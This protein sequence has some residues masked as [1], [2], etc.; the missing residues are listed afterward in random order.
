MKINAV[1]TKPKLL[2]NKAHFESSIVY[3]VS[4][5]LLAFIFGTVICV[6]DNNF[7]SANLFETFTNFITNFSNNSF[8]EVLLSNLFTEII[9]MTTIFLLGTSFIGKIPVY[10]VTFIKMSGIS[11]FVTYLFSSYGISG[12]EY[13]I[14]IMLPST[15]VQIFYVLILN[16]RCSLLSSKIK[17]KLFDDAENNLDIK[18][19]AI[20]TAFVFVLIVISSVL[21]SVCIKLFSSLFEL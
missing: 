21:K 2:K 13:F 15:I 1:F 4:V 20:E 8:L 17:K 5:I 16:E 6:L 19:Y 7:V 10:I 18:N 11:V 12:L 14:I 3:S 9:Y